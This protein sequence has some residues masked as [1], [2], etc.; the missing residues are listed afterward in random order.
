MNVSIP[1]PAPIMSRISSSAAVGRKLRGR[2]GREVGRKGGRDGGSEG[3]R[4]RCEEY[5]TF[6]VLM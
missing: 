2:E 3:G 6:S 1:V 5:L 4:E